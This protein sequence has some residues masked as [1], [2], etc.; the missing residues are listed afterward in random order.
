[1]YFMQNKIP[2]HVGII[3]DGNRRW[4]RV[5][6][7]PAF[8]GHRHGIVAVRK[9]V[10][11]CVELGIKYLTFFTFST[12][13]WER[14]KKEV[15]FLLRLLKTQL[16][17]EIEELHQKGVRFN[18]IGRIKEF[19][20]AL[21]NELYQAMEKTRKNKKTVLSLA[22][23]YGG[24][25]EIVDVVKKIIAGGLRPEQVT[26]EVV[27]QNMYSPFIPDPDLVIRT[28][29]EMRTSGFL[30]WEAAYAELYFTEKYWPDFGEKDLDRAVEEYGK[31]QRRFG[32]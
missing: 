16:R 22:L 2:K 32:K 26:E 1:M 28:S 29:G 7:L 12:E 14:P 27:S 31:R 25:G 15:D 10:Q 11:R 24:R 9:V 8:E 18:V 3:M 20:E 13:N 5:K 23:N 17:K 30:L 19:S 21:Q 4:A 6:D